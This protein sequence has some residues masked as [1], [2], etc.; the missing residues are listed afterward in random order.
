MKHILICD[1]RED[2]LYLLKTLLE[3]N[4]YTADTA[5]NG[6]EALEA[7]RKRRPSVVVSDLLMPVMDGYTLLRH[8]RADAQ[9]R[10]VPFIV[11]T[12]TYTEP[13]D[14]KLA[15][16]LGA[17]AFITKPADPIE[18]LKRLQSV[19]KTTRVAAPA[20]E[21]ARRQ[22][23]TDLLELYSQTLV[24]KLEQRSTQLEQR[25]AEFRVLTEVVPQIIWICQPDGRVT[26]MNPQ[27]TAYTGLGVDESS[28]YNWFKAFHPE[29]QKKV[30]QAWLQAAN[31]PGSYEV[32]CR[33]RRADGA[34]HWWLVRGAPFRGAGEKVVKWFGTCT[35]V[36][37]IKEAEVRIREQAALL[38]KAT[39]AIFVCDLAQCISYWNQGAER[40]FG[41]Q[42]HDVL[43]RDL[44]RIVFKDPA[45]CH[46]AVQLTLSN[47]EWAGE[48]AQVTKDGKSI[49][50]DAR[51]SLVRDSDHNPQCILAINTDITEKKALQAQFLRAQRMESVGRLTGGIVHDFN[52]LLSVVLSSSELILARMAD[53][54]HLKVLAEA[55]LQAAERGTQLTHR[56]LAFARQQPLDPKPTELVALFRGLDVLLNRTL[57]ENI[58]LKFHADEGLWPALVDASQLDHVILN[59]VI[60]ARDA[61]PG[62]GTITIGLDNVTITRE[63]ADE[64]EVAAGDY[65]R[66]QVTDTGLGMDPDTAVKVFE[67]FFTTKEPGQGSGLGLSM[68]HGFV[69]QSKGAIRIDSTPGGGTTITIYLPRASAES[70]V[71]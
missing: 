29:D 30:E 42:G 69:V 36:H 68:A 11:Y 18:F 71:N 66:I 40:V 13:Q 14:E 21:D 16:N 63:T 28:G 24:R 17:D 39:D 19:E 37:D 15:L 48:I 9:L 52:N 64:L 59:L 32:E 56:L 58:E 20:G 22:D 43:G 44:S 10:D 4:G 3:G 55:T 61:M 49:V 38:D 12:A 50:I 41:W 67:P 2:N 7:A 45:E 60:N 62:G 33:I 26:Y 57:G 31:S 1:D 27:W 6:M 23:E 47:G 65:V 8:W 34:Y 53:D 51:W 70:A 5:R 46:K 25:D 35:D 54:D